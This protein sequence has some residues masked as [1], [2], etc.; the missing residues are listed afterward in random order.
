MH[1]NVLKLKAVFTGVDTYC[2]YRSYKHVRVMSNSSIA[3]ESINN[4]GVIES[5]KCN[6]IAKEIWLW[7]FKNSYFISEIHIPGN[8]ILKQTSFLKNLTTMLNGNLILRYLL[9]L[10]IHLGTNKLMYPE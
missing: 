1:I 9:K 8:T 2:H 4:K 10:V 5:K 7:C 3:I 6:K